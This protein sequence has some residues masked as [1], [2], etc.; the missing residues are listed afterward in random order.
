[1]E[2]NK[3]IIEDSDLNKVAGGLS[4]QDVEN[5]ANDVEGALKGIGM[6]LDKFTDLLQLIKKTMGTN[7]CPIC[8]QSIVPLAEKCE[9]TDFVQHIK[10]AHPSNQ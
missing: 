4:V 6:I 9:L 3:K 1:M 5:A 2:E 7:T 8:N 10:A